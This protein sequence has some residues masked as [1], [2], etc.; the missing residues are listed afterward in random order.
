MTDARIEGY[1]RLLVERGVD[2]Q[3]GWQ[4]IIRANPLARPLVEEVMRVIARREAY[5]LLRL[6]YGAPH[7]NLI[8]VDAAWALA[9]PDALLTA[10]PPIERCALEHA[11][12]LILIEA[13]DGREAEAVNGLIARRHLLRQS[14]RPVMERLANGALRTAYSLFPI[15][16]TAPSG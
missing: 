3:P 12:A 4:V 15:R 8:A 1:A 16:Y 7:M 10:M 2:V 14:A 9:A 5:A 11:D 13:P 6:S